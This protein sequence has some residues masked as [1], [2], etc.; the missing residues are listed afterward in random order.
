MPLCRSLTGAQRDVEVAEPA[1]R[2]VERRQVAADH[3]TV[4]DD[5]RV[6]ATDVGLEELDDRV[7]ARLLLAVA[8]EANVH[9][10][11]AGPRE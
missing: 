7:A 3:A 1:R 4:E 9:R 5:R 8:R 6:G 11:L 10:Q 2:D